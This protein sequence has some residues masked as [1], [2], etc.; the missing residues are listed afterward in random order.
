V[1]TIN[2]ILAFALGTILFSSIFAIESKAVNSRADV[3]PAPTGVEI[4]NS[5]NSQNQGDE[6]QLQIET[7]DQQGTQSGQGDNL[8]TRN[9]TA[10]QN[11]SIVAE[12]VQ[13]LLQLKTTGGIGDQVRQIAR[14]QEQAQTK[15]Q[16][17]LQKID[18]KGVLAK[19]LLGPDYN[20]INRLEEQLGQNKLNVQELQQLQ[21]QLTNKEDQKAVQEAIQALIRVNESLQARIDAENNTFNMFGW[22][23]RLFA[24]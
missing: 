15:I 5:I 11:M 18:S 17:H 24:K 3:S 6:K 13:L 1:K 23:F 21:T 4:K 20:S 22:I 14:D 7:R 16:E 8:E 2:N 10:V 19:L 9:Q 12:K